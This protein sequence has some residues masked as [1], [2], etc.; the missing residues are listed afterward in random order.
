MFNV[1]ASCAVPSDRNAGNRRPVSG[2]LRMGLHADAA[3]IAVRRGEALSLAARFADDDQRTVAALECG[4]GDADDACGDGHALQVAAV[5]KGARAD[6]LQAVR[7]DDA[8]E[9]AAG[10]GFRTD[11]S[12]LGGKGEG[13]TGLIERIRTRVKAKNQSNSSATKTG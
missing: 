6:G 13:M 7:A 11:R 8:C 9:R 1:H 4:I 2:F 5:R 12:E 3:R 10:K